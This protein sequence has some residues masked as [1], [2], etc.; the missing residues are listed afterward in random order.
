ML[1]S[2]SVAFSE[3]DSTLGESARVRAV[4]RGGGLLVA[5]STPP[6]LDH[7]YEREFVVTGSRSVIAYHF[8]M[9]VGDHSV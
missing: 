7:F 6:L 5:L 3:Q 8:C 4:F 9:R 1:L 2:A